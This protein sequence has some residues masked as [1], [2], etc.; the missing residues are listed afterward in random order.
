MP[1]YAPPQWIT[2]AGNLGTIPEL[3]YIELPLDAYDPNGGELHYSLVSGKLPKGLRVVD[4]TFYSSISSGAPFYGIQ[5]V[6]VSELQGDVSVEYKFT[7]RVKNNE[8]N[9]IADRTFALT[10]TNVAPPVILPKDLNLGIF[11]DG[12]T[13]DLQLNALDVTPGATLTWSLA[14]GELPEGLTLSESGKLSGYIWP[15]L[16]PGPD[17]DPDW[18][19]TGWDS[20][21]WAFYRQALRKAFEFVVQVFDGVNYDRSYY[22]IEV[23]PRAFLTADNDNVNFT[24]D[25]EYLSYAPVIFSGQTELV[26]DLTGPE[27]TVDTGKLHH[28]IILTTQDDFPRVRQNTNFSF[29]IEA[30]DLDYDE[31]KY[32]ITSYGLGLFDVGEESPIPYIAS[33]AVDGYLYDGV[34]P[35]ITVL[36]IGGVETVTVDPEFANYEQGDTVKI[37]DEDNYWRIATIT[38]GVVVRITGENKITANPGNYLTS[39]MG[40]ANATVV[41]SG[42][43]VGTLTISYPTSFTVGDVIEQGANS[44][45]VTSNVFLSSTVQV[46]ATTGTFTANAGNITINSISSNVYPISV[47]YY[48]DIKATYNNAA[49]FGLSAGFPGNVAD[50]MYVNGVSTESYATSIQ[51]LGV[52]VSLTLADEGEAGY[53]E[54]GV[55]F[56]QTVLGL[57]TTLILDENSGWLTGRIP[58]QTF[59]VVRYNFEVTV[60]KKNDFTYEDRQIYSLVV[61]GDLYNFVSWV[62]PENLGT[63]QN[64][65][66]SDFKVEAVNSVG[67]PLFYRLVEHHRLPQG[68]Q[69]TPNGLIVG[70][71]SFRLFTLDKSSTTIDG[72]DT[73]FDRIHRFTVEAID[74]N[75]VSSATRT[76][77][78]TVINRN[79]TPYENLYLQALPKPEQRDIFNSVIRDHYIFPPELIYRAEDPW[80]G[81]TRDIRSLFLPGLS[82]STLEEYTLAAAQNHF[83]KRLIFGDVKTAAVVDDKFETKYEVVYIELLDEN[84]NSSG[85][86]P[87]S[88]INLVNLIENPYYDAQGNSYNVA[89]PNAF[90]NMRDRIVN[91]LSYTNKGALPEWMTSNQPTEDGGFTPPIGFVRAVVLAFTVP[92]AA[93]L[94]A[95]RLKEKNV[96]LNQ[97]NFTLD[98]YHLDNVLSETYNVTAEQYISTPE[99]TFDRY[100]G[101]SAVYTIA[102]SVDY[103][104]T[105]SFDSING[106]TVRE[107]SSTGVMDEAT[108]FQ[109]GDTI[110]F[111][112]QEFNLDQMDVDEYNQG[113]YYS[114]SFWSGE[115][116]EDGQLTIPTEDDIGWDESG[117]IPGY[118]EHLMDAGLPSTTFGFPSNPQDR[119]LF[120]KDEVIYV[121]DSES[122]T[123]KIPNQRAG[124][125]QVRVTPSN[126]VLLYFIKTV[127]YYERLYVREGARYGRKNIYYNPIIQ[128]NRNFPSYTELGQT[129]TIDYTTF[130]GNGTRFFDNRDNSI[131]PGE[132]NKYIKFNK[133]NVFI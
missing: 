120:T 3:E 23:M 83:T 66:I 32:D 33:Q 62:T 117:Y 63:I 75:N 101:L 36:N 104:V 31:L 61:Y 78:I 72:D 106:K 34:W 119:Q 9:Y 59:N 29:K 25:I 46:T 126:T 10:V 89:Y 109:D 17:E 94:M 81:I 52:S 128:E 51:A 80:F 99:T 13:V 76:F 22:R 47:S 12:S 38:N 73:T 18:D 48:T 58:A 114:K 71:V 74:G 95:F 84:S 56:D 6:P 20:F 1:Q 53:D 42:P 102:G 115:P 116:W 68:L 4:G 57:P 91:E 7:V 41:S 64:G 15:I 90:N 2:Q 113:W 30:I 121:Y 122:D 112:N 55:K 77:Y 86:A 44:A 37:L 127:E 125:W 103:A 118:V 132:G 60:R 130:D 26:V 124:I 92:G 96:N 49:T 88:Q 111:F 40:G 69:L 93:K 97:I 123:W 110:V 129:I 35:K 87:N 105:A 54:E 24:V 50:K 67:I 16:T 21:D 11:F 65:R 107:I 131:I 45:V 108:D 28:P 82:P 133:T 8:T 98:R 39:F 14:G 43:T 5:G 27:V 85:Q 70:R 100:S 19:R 79:I